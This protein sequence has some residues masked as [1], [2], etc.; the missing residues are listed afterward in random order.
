MADLMTNAQLAQLINDALAKWNAREAEQYAWVSGSAT[1]GP[2]GDGRFPLSNGSGSSNLIDS[3]AKLADLLNGPAALAGAA[4]DEAQVFRDAAQSAATA[5]STDKTLANNSKL[6]AQ[7]AR[8][9]AMLYR[10]Q[11]AA[12]QATVSVSEAAV[13]AALASVTTKEAN[14]ITLHGET[15]VAR[16]DAVVAKTAAEAAAALAATFNPNDY[17]TKV[18]SDGRYVQLT[19]FNW[20]S[21]SNKPGVFPPEAHTHIIS[22]ITGLQAALDGKQ[23]AGSYVTTANFTWSNLSGKPT[24]FTPSA[25][26]HLISEITGLQ[27][28]L[29]GKAA[30][31][32]THS[33][34]PLT[35]GTLSGIL[36]ANGGVWSNHVGYNPA[37]DGY[38]LGA[39]W[40]ANYGMSLGEHGGNGTGLATMLSG[41]S[42]LRFA[43]SSTTRLYVNSAGNVIASVDLRAPIFYDNDNTAFFL[44]PSSTS[45][46][47]GINLNVLNNPQGFRVMDFDGPDYT[48]LRGPDSAIRFY[49]GR[50]NV[51]TYYDNDNHIFR[52]DGGATQQL[53]ISGTG[54][55][56]ASVDM[57][58]PIFYDSANTGYYID[59]AST[60]NLNGLLVSGRD[61]RRYG[62]NRWIEFT[63]G[64]DANT[65]YP[66]LLQTPFYLFEFAKWSITR[67]Y[68]DPAPWDPIGTGVH[69]GGLTLTWCWSGDGAW[70]G[71]DKAHRVEQFHESYTTMVAGMFLS[72][73]GMIVWLRGGGAVY[74]LHGPGGLDNAVS[75]NLTTYTAGNGATFSPRSYDAATVN[76]EIMSRYPIRNNG[77]GGELWD[78]NTRV[79]SED[80]WINSKY[81]GSNGTIYGGTFYDSSNSAF[82]VDPAGS[83]YLNTVN[84]GIIVAQSSNDAQLYLNGNGTSWAGIAFTD[85]SNSDYLWYNGSTSTFAVGGGGATGTNKKLHVNGGATVGSGLATSNVSANGLLV[86]ARIDAPIFYDSNDT[87]YYLNPSSS[88]FLVALGLQADEGLNVRG[89]RGGFTGGSDSQGIHLF[90]NVDIGY[91]SGW[92]VGLSNTPS[93]GL[94]V[95][96][97]GR[98]AYSGSGFLSADTSVRA[99]IFYDSNN[100]G[101][102]L[103]PAT[104]SK[105]RGLFEVE[106]DHYNTEIRLTATGLG[107]GVN[108]AMSWW[109]SEPDVTWN[110]G[111]FGFNVTNDGGSPNGF[112][113]LNT[114][115]GQAYT[116]YTY[117]GNMLFYCTDTGGNRYNVMSLYSNNTIGVDNMLYA[118]GSLRAPIFYDNDNTGYYLDAAATG[119]SLN[120]AGSIVAAGNV[121]AYSDA[122][123]KDNIQTI[124]GALSKVQQ[125]TGVTYTRNDLTD[126]TRRYAGL[127]AQDVQKVLPEA[128]KDMGGALGVDYSATIGL[129][130]EAIKELTAEI[131]T[132]KSKG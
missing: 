31:G 100:T 107:S 52:T 77:Q 129:L 102:Y 63:V 81:F 64:G 24:T 23:A 17:Y 18:A 71:N 11:T 3:P 67:H 104:G 87:G 6:A 90:S 73:S 99:P 48:L 57:R 75:V 125:I 59:P 38:T 14:V 8:D 36:I 88:S 2:N 60:S 39:G 13:A 80:R 128:V 74:K 65:Y 124:S 98:F 27:T 132:L 40:V 51:P 41:Y 96:G 22:E 69:R 1:G 45:R 95:Y 47:S 54:N 108:S 9:L 91:P 53:S 61:M 131:E 119:T 117:N 21:L 130:V 83:S 123:L 110:D 93:R 82:Y 94:S 42:G 5:A 34:L 35:G 46:M 30:T 126:K 12:L 66:V 32:H 85:V 33:Y 114:D 43:T 58:A 121:T 44:D 106:G 116:R 86:E 89:I 4:R 68:A 29:D 72:T 120:V 112:G 20:S 56:I 50:D 118:V 49:I 70:G 92:G 15:L 115:F 28:E 111:G 109:V 19:N 105:I 122:R 26:T 84:A 25:H 10:D 7:D 55:V 101:Y 16:D 37:G 97:G 62:T 78:G 76:T 103:D 113:R 127:I 79:L